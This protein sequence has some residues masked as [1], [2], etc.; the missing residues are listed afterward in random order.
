MFLFKVKNPTNTFMM[1][2]VDLKL[3][4]VKI[5]V[6]EK[7]MSATDVSFNE[8]NQTVRLTFSEQ[9]NKGL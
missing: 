6:G 4:A 8:K 2:S 3:K 9:L 1:N 7:S 5:S